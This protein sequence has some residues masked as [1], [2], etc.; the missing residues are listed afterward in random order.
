MLLVR[1]DAEAAAAGQSRN[2]FIVASLS[3]TLQRRNLER[4]ERMEQ[5]FREAR[6]CYADVEVDDELRHLHRRAEGIMQ[7]TLPP[8]RMIGGINGSR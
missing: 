6:A 1:I 5:V 4:V 7:E 2:A 3:E 8:F